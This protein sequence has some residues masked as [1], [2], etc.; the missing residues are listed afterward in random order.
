MQSLLFVDDKIFETLD[1]EKIPLINGVISV[2]D[3]S[4]ISAKNPD[5][6]NKYL[7]LDEKYQK[8][9]PDLKPDDIK[10][11]DITNDKLAVIS[12]TGGTTGG[13]KGSNVIS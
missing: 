10:F 11:S 3:F 6:K 8:A 1:K 12:Y 2:D 7:A 13:S 9:Y 5:L 4:M